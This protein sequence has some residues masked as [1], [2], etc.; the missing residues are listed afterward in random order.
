MEP[1]NSLI[2]LTQRL[3]EDLSAGALGVPVLPQVAGDTLSL[4]SS[5]D[6][7][8]GALAQ[9]IE[10]DQ[11]LA[12]NLLRIA[13]SPAYRGTVE[14]VALPQALTRLGLGTIRDIALSITMQGLSAPLIDLHALAQ[15]F[16]Q[17]SLSTALWAREIAR[18][19]PKA[20][21]EAYLCGL[22]H[23]IGA[24][25]VLHWLAAQ[26]E[27]VSEADAESLALEHADEAGVCLVDSWGLPPLVV[28]AIHHAHPE[29]TPDAVKTVPRAEELQAIISLA[30]ALHATTDD[31]EGC[32]DQLATLPAT[33]QLGLD[34]EGLGTLLEHKEAVQA[35]LEFMSG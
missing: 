33:R 18:C 19:N 26:Q 7:D 35:Q 6:T 30:R 20:V 13:N 12:S 23:N 25:V 3:A 10:R 4:C 32:I 9:L 14:I 2:S 1:A 24:T 27:Q 22:M 16:W 31:R 17:Q 34:Q 11:A 29:S 28:V 15:R 8:I 5:Q 21:D